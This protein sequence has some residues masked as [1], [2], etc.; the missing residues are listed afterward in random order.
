MQK[1]LNERA[2]TIKLLTGSIDL[3]F[4]DLVLNNGFLNM[5]PQAQI[6]ATKKNQTNKPDFTKIKVFVQR[7]PLR[8]YN[9]NPQNRRKYLQ[10]K[11]LIKV[12]YPE[13]IK[14]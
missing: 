3:S 8:K 4:H 5:T 6:T 12:W 10:I 9:D 14:N 1:D 2:K 13:Y 11:R 7:K